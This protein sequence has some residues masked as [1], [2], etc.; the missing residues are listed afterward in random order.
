[1][2]GDE[3]LEELTDDEDVREEFG[4]MLVKQNDKIDKA[5]KKGLTKCPMIDVRPTMRARL[6]AYYTQMIGYRILNNEIHFNHLKFDQSTLSLT[7]TS[8]VKKLAQGWEVE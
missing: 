7:S 1:M 8:F 5:R 2:T 3:L 6:L 4:R